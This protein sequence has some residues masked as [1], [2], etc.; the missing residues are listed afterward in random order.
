MHGTMTHKIMVRSF[1]PGW[2]LWQT[3]LYLTSKWREV[4]LPEQTETCV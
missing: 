2:R 4:L 3:Y 1:R